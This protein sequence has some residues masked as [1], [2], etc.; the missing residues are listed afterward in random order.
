MA[1]SK[2]QMELDMEPLTTAT[3]TRTRLDAKDP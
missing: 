2:T 3:A 1:D